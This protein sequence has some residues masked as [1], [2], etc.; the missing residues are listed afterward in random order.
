[1]LKLILTIAIAGAIAGAY[2]NSTAATVGS[3]ARAR[4]TNIK[5]ITRGLVCIH[6][7]EGSWTAN[8]GNGYYGGLQMDRSFQIHY[9]KEFYYSLGTAD[10]WPWYIQLAV[11]VKGYLDRGWYPWPITARRCGL[12]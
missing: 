11:G 1:M 8:T 9:G 5:T 12:F 6:R 3:T 2:T 4:T 10:R 7:L